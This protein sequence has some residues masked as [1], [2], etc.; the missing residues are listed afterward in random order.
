[1][2]QYLLPCDCGAKTPVSRSQAGVSLPCSGCGT[3]L[4]VPTIRNMAKLAVV[5]EAST[6]AKNKAGK[7]SILLGLIAALALSVGIATLAYGGSLAW[8]QYQLISEIT[9]QKVDLSNDEED[10]VREIRTRRLK[11]TPA[12]TWDYWN[13]LVNEGLNEPDPPEFFKIKRFID[14]R[15]PWISGSLSVA[16]VSLSIFAI[17]GFLMQRLRR[18]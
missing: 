14:S 9:E 11:A 17:S 15:K 5:S 6:K 2:S 8:D 4:D 7:P 13:I 10:F 3:P 18:K 1:M 12:D 16:A